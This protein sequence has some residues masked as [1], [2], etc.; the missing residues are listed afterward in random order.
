MVILDNKKI[1][2]EIAEKGAEIRRCTVNCEDRFWSGDPKYWSGVAPV[3]FPV[4]S[5]LKDDKFTINGKSYN[6]EKHGFAKKM[7]FTVEE[8]GDAYA[9]FLLTSTEETLKSYPWTF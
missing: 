2:L 5:G 9:V 8:K 7:D 1:R 3:L 6:L 4:C